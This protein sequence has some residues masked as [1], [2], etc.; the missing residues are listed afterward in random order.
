MLRAQPVRPGR[1]PS[2]STRRAALA[3]PGVR[4]RVHRRRPE[5]R[6]ARSSGTRS[7]GP[8]RPETPAPAARRGR[9]ALRR[10]PG[11]AR[12]RRDRYLAEDA[13]ELVDVDYE[14]LPAGR[15][16][17][18]RPRP[19]TSSCTRATARTSSAS[20][21]VGPASALDDVFAA[22][23][24]VVER[25]D[26]PAGVRRGADGEA[27]ASSS[28]TSRRDRRAHDLRGDAVAARGAAVLLAACSACPSTASAW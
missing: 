16:L 8:R 20:S 2:A 7:I 5:P 15:R 14:P 17:R 24:H 26:L 28:T 4:A 19:P 25:D 27:A 11:R 12:R 10:R 3:L 23:A 9:G 13:A 21:P 22:A 1:D 6:R 18:R